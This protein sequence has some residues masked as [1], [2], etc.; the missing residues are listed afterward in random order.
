MII[1]VILWLFCQT[2]TGDGISKSAIED[3]AVMERT[4]AVPK[5]EVDEKLEYIALPHRGLIFQREGT[6]LSHPQENLLTIVIGIKRPDFRSNMGFVKGCETDL[7]PVLQ[8]FD[9]YMIMYAKMANAVFQAKTIFTTDQICE[10][11]KN[12]TDNTN[13]CNEPRRQK[14]LLAAGAY[15]MSAASMAMSAAAIGMAGRNIAEIEKI[16]NFLKTHEDDIANIQSELGLARQRQDVIID[17][18]KSLLG[19]VQNLTIH[20]EKLSN[21]VTCSKLQ[22]QYQNIH[23]NEVNEVSEQVQLKVIQFIFKGQTHGRLN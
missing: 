10:I 18:Q 13:L 21:Q 5:I 6:I 15:V 17:T 8:N 23:V 2:D 16:K 20:V 14:R 11:T 3:I 9:N 4:R 22:S 1:A 19:Y 7:E 12:D